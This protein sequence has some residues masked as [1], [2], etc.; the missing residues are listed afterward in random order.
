MKLVTTRDLEALQATMM[1]AGKSSSTIHHTLSLF[2]A[3]WNWA[4]KRQLISGDNPFLIMDRLKAEGK[5]ERYFKAE[6]LQLVLNWLKEKKSFNL[7]INS[8]CSSYRSTF[9]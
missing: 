3:T 9:R 2:R 5:R 6:E 8:V 7:P 4:R 1:D